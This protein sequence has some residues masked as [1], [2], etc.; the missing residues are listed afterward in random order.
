MPGRTTAGDAPIDLDAYFARIGYSGP[1]EATPEVLR[2]LHYLHPL[3]IAFEN[4]DPLLRRGVRLDPASLQEKLVRAGRGGYCFEQNL[5]FSHVLKALGFRL[6]GLAARILWNQPEDAV[7]ARGHMLLRVEIDA[8]TY[9][10]DVG[11]GGLT[12]TAPLLLAPGREQATPHEPFRLVAE[13]QSFRMQAKLG[14]AW[15]SLYRF[16]LQEQFQVDYEVSNYYL[17]THPASHFLKTIIAARPKEKGRCALLDNR[18]TLHH[19]DGRSERR[20]LATPAEIREV[21]EQTFGV[22]VPDRAAF[23]AAIARLGLPASS[24]PR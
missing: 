19:P 16:D 3:A 24:S 5:L 22:V 18:L 15:R 23:D 13:G 11:F 21:L 6:S 8:A 7:T 12:L 4:L 1:R 17:S 9:L 2:A 10:A 14:E 20:E